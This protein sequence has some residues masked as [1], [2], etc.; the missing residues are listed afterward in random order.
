MSVVLTHVFESALSDFV[1]LPFLF[2]P[3]HVA[4]KGIQHAT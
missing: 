4:K 1:L 2:L 3:L